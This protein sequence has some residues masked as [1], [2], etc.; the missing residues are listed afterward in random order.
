MCVNRYG[1]ERAAEC[2]CP[3]RGRRTGKAFSMMCF[4]GKIC[5]VTARNASQGAVALVY[6]ERTGM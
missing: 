5:Q 6:H 1:D 2:R 3:G 4:G